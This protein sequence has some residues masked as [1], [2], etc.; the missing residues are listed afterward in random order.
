MDLREISGI[1]N[2]LQKVGLARCEVCN[3]ETRFSDVNEFKGTFLCPECLQKAAWETEDT[4][5]LP[6]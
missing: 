6:S 4:I 5:E 2:K 3:S 1:I